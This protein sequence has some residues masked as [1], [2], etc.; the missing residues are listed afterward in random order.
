LCYTWRGAIRHPSTGEV[1]FGRLAVRRRWRMAGAAR[2][3]GCLI[4][5]GILAG[6]EGTAK[7]DLGDLQ[8]KFATL[9]KGQKDLAAKLD[10][11]GAKVGQLETS[12]AAVKEELTGLAASGKKAGEAAT[13]LLKKF[14]GIE[15]KVAQ[16]QGEQAQ[17]KAQS[18]DLLQKIAILTADIEKRFLDMT[19]KISAAKAPAPVPPPPPAPVPVAPKPVAPPPVAPAPTR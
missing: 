1:V 9:E 8:A 4:V 16:V 14:E 10:E 2:F 19:A 15:G 6:C 11:W 12:F 17:A 5:L 13:D 3:V 18:T 7:K